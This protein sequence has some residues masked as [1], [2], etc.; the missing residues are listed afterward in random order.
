MM[1]LD[2]LMVESYPGESK[3]SEDEQQHLL[4]SWH[5]SVSSW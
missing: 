4:I 3:L 5:N 1:F 2:I